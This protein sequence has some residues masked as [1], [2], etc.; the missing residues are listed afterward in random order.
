MRARWKA[1]ALVLSLAFTSPC[2]AK[3]GESS[4]YLFFGEAF[5]PSLL[6][7]NVKS[8]EMALGLGTLQV[9]KR[10]WKDQFYIGTGAV[11]SMS[12]PGYY[13]TYG[14]EGRIAGSVGFVGEITG[15]G[16]VGGDVTGIAW[17]GLGIVF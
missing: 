13:G 10:F 3:S 8:F 17:F 1:A 6:R 16:T 9:G 7:L 2:F 5:L 15:Y 14:W 4:V 12:G 11:L